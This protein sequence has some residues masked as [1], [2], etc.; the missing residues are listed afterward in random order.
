MELHKSLKRATIFLS[1][2]LSLQPKTIH[3]IQTEAESNP[4]E[5]EREREVV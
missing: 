1:F 2:D 4:T 5:R 3:L